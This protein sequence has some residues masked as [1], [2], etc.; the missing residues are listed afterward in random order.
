[1]AEERV[2]SRER[3]EREKKGKRVRREEGEKRY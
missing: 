2:K 1:M 3:K